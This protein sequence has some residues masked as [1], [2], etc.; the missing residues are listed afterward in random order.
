[1]KQTTFIRVWFESKQ[2]GRTAGLIFPVE[3]LK[4]KSVSEISRYFPYSE[5]MKMER[6]FTSPLFDSWEDAFNFK[7]EGQ[8]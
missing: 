8:Q 3:Q 5:A 1:M 2:H 4:G 6:F 7:I